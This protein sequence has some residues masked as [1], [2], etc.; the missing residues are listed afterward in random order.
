MK[1]IITIAAIMLSM[2]FLAACSKDKN[3]TPNNNNNG[4]NNQ[5]TLSESEK[6]LVGKWVMVKDIDS[7]FSHGNLV[8]VTDRTKPCQSDDVFI[9]SDNKKY[10]KDEGLDSCYD[11]GPY[12]EQSWSIDEYN[13]LNYKHGYDTWAYGGAFTKLDDNQFV[14]HS[15]YNYMVTN[16]GS[17]TLYYKRK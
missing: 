9:F 15:T 1:P 12:T 6:F 5:S 16:Y 11:A 2:Q 17:H 14:V 10:R 7:N 13:K 4:N 8:S 3:T